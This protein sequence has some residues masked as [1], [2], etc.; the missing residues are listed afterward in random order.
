MQYG[1]TSTYC[2]DLSLQIA[3]MLERDTRKYKATVEV[4]TT[5]EVVTVDYDDLCEYTGDVED[6]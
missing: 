5:S 2:T 1:I 6:L 4:V 3:R